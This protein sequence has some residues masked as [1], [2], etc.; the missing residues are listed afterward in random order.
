MPACPKIPRAGTFFC[1]VEDDPLIAQIAEKLLESAGRRVRV[2]A[3][4]LEV[5]KVVPDLK[6]DV[7]ITDI[8][9]AEL[10]RLALCERLR[11]KIPLVDTKLVILSAKAC[12]F[13]Q[14]RAR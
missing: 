3:S 12:G 4:S 1:L 7:V 10:D 2:H 14:E 11:K 6:P 13:D 9:M 8:M 5:A